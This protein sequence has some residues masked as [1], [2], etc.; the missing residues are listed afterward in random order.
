MIGLELECSKCRSTIN[1]TRHFKK[2][3][4]RAVE[5]GFNVDCPN[6]GRLG[7]VRGTRDADTDEANHQNEKFRR[8][9][10]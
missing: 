4:E 2:I 3:A 5:D 6:C 8:G 7:E 10:I 1:A 9:R